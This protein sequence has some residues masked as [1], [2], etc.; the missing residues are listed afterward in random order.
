M[1][2]PPPAFAALEAHGRKRARTFRRRLPPGHRARVGDYLRW[3]ARQWESYVA[4][5]K[6]GC[7]DDWIETSLTDRRPE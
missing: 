3:L 7:F 4:A 2:P 1:T 5:G 6:P